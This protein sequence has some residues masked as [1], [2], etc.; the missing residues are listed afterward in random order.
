MTVN[1]P[2]GGEEYGF[3]GERLDLNAYLHRVGYGGGLDPTVEVLRGLQY[4]HATT[5]PFENLGV[6]LGQGVFLELDAIQDKLVRS[7]RGGYCF[8]H[9][10]LFAALLER[11]GFGVTGLLGR[12]AMGSDRLRPE[13]HALLQ[14]DVPG[15]ATPWL[16]DTGFGALAP[17]E[18]IPLVDAAH[19]RQGNGWH[20]RVSYTE[21]DRAGTW[22]L[23]TWQ[24]GERITLYRFSQ[25]PRYPLDYGVANHYTS[26]HPRS[27]FVGA[28]R[29][30]RRNADERVML[31]DRELSTHAPSG[32]AQHRLL[33]PEELP[34][35]LSRHV[36]V[37]LDD[38]D[39]ALLVRR[40][41]ETEQ[42]PAVSS[43]PLAS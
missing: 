38:T 39:A 9:T 11:L 10:L 21:A 16:V 27:P 25:R 18:P 4:A 36:G 6:L 2:A 29:A 43:A 23:V 20:Y 14:V 5:I 32:E 26:T 40:Y 30:Q 1:D 35:A 8:E 19:S 24:R 22:S 15:S 13:T 42:L 7:A 28:L 41:A 12:V 34:G 37:V 31:A 3:S 17:L 33:R